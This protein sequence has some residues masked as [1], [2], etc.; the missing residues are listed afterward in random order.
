LG[1]ASGG[2]STSFSPRAEL[3]VDWL[4]PP[5]QSLA[6]GAF[7]PAQALSSAADALEQRRSTRPTNLLAPPT[8]L[9]GREHEIEQIC[10]LLR[11]TDIR[12]LMLTDPGGIGKTR[13]GLQV[14]ADLV[15]EFTDGVL[16]VDLAPIRDSNLV[17]S[18]IPQTLGVREIGGQPL[19]E[20]LKNYLRDKQM[21]LLDKFEQ[22]VDAATLVAELLATSAEL[23][24]LVT[25]R[26]N[27]HLRGEQEIA[28]PSLGLPHPS[29]LP[30]VERLTQYGR[31]ALFIQHARAIQPTFQL[32]N[33]NAPSVAEICVRL[34]GLPLAI[35]LAAAR[36]KLF[37]PEALL[38]RLDE[39]LKFLIGGARD[40][41]ERQQTI[42]N[43]ID[44]SYHSWD[45]D[46]L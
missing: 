23:K 38:I 22:V 13:L 17:G 16:F 34:D 44:W 42:R 43:T 30:P 12:L 35:E 2:T 14:A 24:V 45:N 10:A 6:R 27:L 36:F 20:R 1:S 4:A 19:L 11:C 15:E 3:G 33:A 25:S 9:I 46:E 29:Q 8:A 32:T 39:R 41:S 26:E 18:A 31:I 7:V 40:L 21:L 5:A 37:A 28:V